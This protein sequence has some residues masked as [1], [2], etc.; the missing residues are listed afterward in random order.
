MGYNLGISIYCV[1]DHSIDH[2]ID[3]AEMNGF[4]RIELW[5]L[6]TSDA[7]ERLVEYLT[8]SKR[9]L[10]VHVDPS[11]NIGNFNKISDNIDVLREY[12]GQAGNWGVKR[13]V[14]HTG[15]VTG[16]SSRKSIN[17]AE[18]VINSILELLEEYQIILC[19]ENVG[20]IRG[21]IIRDFRQLV[22]F[23]DKF[24]RDLVGVA[25][26][27]S[28]AN[29]TEGIGSGIETLGSHIIEVH[30]SDNLG[31]TKKHHLPSGK[32]NIDF[33][34]L[35]GLQ[36]QYNVTNVTAILEITPDDSWEKNLLDS[37]KVLQELGLIE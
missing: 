26:D 33:S 12:L 11:W 2:L 37:R 28:H 16:D 31:K 6:P 1:P 21:E 8:E 3:F 10:S 17:A 4:H 15:V 36:Y 25:F 35:K 24:P 18:K 34:Q 27:L 13:A 22:N 7:N 9:E 5:D 32:G 23:V 30:L 14:L 20:Y 19:I 29:I